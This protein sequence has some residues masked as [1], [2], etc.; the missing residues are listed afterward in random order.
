MEAG[1]FEPAADIIINVTALLYRWGLGRLAESLSQQLIPGVKKETQS[2]LI[3]NLGILLQNRGD[4]QAALHQYEKSL[5]I[6]EE[7]GNRTNMARSLHEIGNIHNMQG[8]YQAALDQ[9]EKSLKIFEEFGD[10]AGVASSLN[11]IGAIH[12]D[13]GDY[14]AALEQYERSLKIEEKIGARDGMAR[15][16]HQ[17]GRIHHVRE[18]YQEALEMY[19]KSLTIFSELQS[20]DAQEAIK[21]LIKLRTQWGA[22]H[23]DAAWKERTG[24]GVPEVLKESGG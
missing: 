15:S 8:D 23:F 24:E 6:A 10:S 9:Y 14:P 21:N 17:I 7:L 18:A 4:Y 22:E 11:N 12:H 2:G 5:K 19:I 16:L 20:P 13:R 3:H 1:E